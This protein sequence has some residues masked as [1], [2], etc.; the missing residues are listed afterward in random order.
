[1]I[2]CQMLSN[3]FLSLPLRRAIGSIAFVMGAWLPSS[4]AA[5]LWLVMPISIASTNITNSDIK[6]LYMGRKNAIGDV[7]VTPF[8]FKPDA[9]ERRVFLKSI[10]EMD[11]AEYV[12][13]W[14]VRRFSGQ[15]VSPIEVSSS[16]DLMAKLKET[17]NGVGY[18]VSDEDKLPATPAGYTLKLIE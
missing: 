2:M 18:L 3:R 14:Y 16:A 15:G 1:M 5:D 8:N 7:F 6:K 13:Y 10:V 17:K 12:G 11:E 9:A 4:Y